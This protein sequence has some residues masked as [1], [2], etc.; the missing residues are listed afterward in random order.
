M[1]IKEFIKDL[2]NDNLNIRKYFSNPE[3]LEISLLELENVI[4]MKKIKGQILKQI[5][6]FISSNAKGIY[7]DSDRKHC[8]LCGPPGCGKTTVGKILCKIWVS[9]GFIGKT[10]N[11]HK[12]K[13]PTFNKIQDELIRRQRVELTEYKSKVRGYKICMNNITKV[14]TINRR[15]LNNLIT[16]QHSIN[17]NVYESLMSDI[18]STLKILDKGHR[19][20]MKTTSIE[21]YIKNS[22]ELSSDKSME[23]TGEEL[24]APFNVYN[25]NDVISRYVGDTAHRCTKAMNDSLDGVAYF[26]EAYNLCNDS[27]G[28]S[29]T[30]GREALTTINQYMDTHSARIIVVFAGYKDDIYNNLFRVQ[31]GLE[32]R[33]TNKFDIEAYTAEE[34][35][36]IFIQRLSKSSWKMEETPGLVAIIRENMSIFKYQ[37][38]DMDT[39]AM[40]T[41]NIVSE[42]IYESVLRKEKIPD[43]IT[44]LNIVKKAVAIFKQNSIGNVRE[45]NDVD[46][47]MDILRG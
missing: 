12:V 37:G 22:I 38:R 29:D 3:D 24:D 14:S 31:K 15:I 9:I 43:K 13:Y 33:F 40:Y 10:G 28:M 45:R 41:K 32:S 1:S 35:T 46:R 18:S 47:V 16:Q 20:M 27:H 17:P 7:R 11:K 44:D 21:S 25:R 8:L 30:Y 2:N 6:T 5:K 23:D 36:K 4:G 26:D 39:L 42:N 19:D 34:L